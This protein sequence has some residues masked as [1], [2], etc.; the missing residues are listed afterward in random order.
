MRR[1][2]QT[3]LRIMAVCVVPVVSA[4]A[5]VGQTEPVVFCC[6]GYDKP[7][8]ESVAFLGIDSGRGK[9]RD[10]AT[11]R[12]VVHSEP[13]VKVTTQQ[14]I[15][16]HESAVQAVI[17]PSIADQDLGPDATYQ[18]DLSECS[19]AIGPRVSGWS[20]VGRTVTG[21]IGGAIGGIWIG[22]MASGFR[23]M[24]IG[25]LAGLAAGGVTGYMSSVSDES[26]TSQYDVA[27]CMALRG[28]R[29]TGVIDR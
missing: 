22:G 14:P 9:S 10:V 27:K 8:Y 1:M 23:G 7:Q 19:V 3:R 15:I 13:D 26:T 29:S 4:C 2:R 11:Q 18:A 21:A 17:Q 25:S 6:S 28:H 16:D 12:P 5:T 20:R 24:A